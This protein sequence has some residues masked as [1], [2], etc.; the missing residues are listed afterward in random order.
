MSLQSPCHNCTKR[1]VHCH[2]VCRDYL[3]QR[4]EHLRANATRAREND[5]KMALFFSKQARIIKA[6]RR[7]QK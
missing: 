7:K 1:D 4:E 6:L 2:E 5:I 3:E